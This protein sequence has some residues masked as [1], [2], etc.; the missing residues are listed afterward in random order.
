M[1]RPLTWDSTVEIIYLKIFTRD[2]LNSK[3][4]GGSPSAMQHF[5]VSFVSYSTKG[6]T[7]SCRLAL[8]LQASYLSLPNARPGH[9]LG[10]LFLLFL[11]IM[12]LSMSGLACIY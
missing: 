7:M 10:F 3:N 9:E 2:I 1:S 4:V 11:D 8:D 6:L 12:M 5:N